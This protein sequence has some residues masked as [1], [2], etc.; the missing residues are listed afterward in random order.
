MFTLGL[1]QASAS[2]DV[3]QNIR[4]IQLFASK[5]AEKSC[6]ALC[7]PEAFLTS[8]LP[9]KSSDLA[10]SRNCREL[11]KVLYIAIKN[12]IDILVGFMERENDRFY[13]TH[14]IFSPNGNMSFYRK[15]HLGEREQTVFTAGDSLDIFTLS[16]GLKAGIQLCVET[17]FPEITQTL[18][19]LGADIIFAPHA[20]P[21]TAGDRSLIWPKYIPARSYDNRVYIACCNQWDENRFGGGCLVADPRGNITAS[22]FADLEALL[23]FTVIPEELQ[24]YHQENASARYRYYPVKRR[25]ELYV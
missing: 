8:Y 23:V 22:C 10:L 12:R 5:A 3:D 16:N 25:P 15:T 11:Q 18:S 20:I 14:G 17:H 6:S 21:R 19:L 7:F 4:S 2:A 13:L 24:K 9:A 1:V